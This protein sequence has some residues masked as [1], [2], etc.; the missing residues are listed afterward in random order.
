MSGAG[1]VFNRIGVDSVSSTELNIINPG[2]ASASLVVELVSSGSSPILMPL[3]LAA[4]GVAQ[5]DVATFFGVSEV[6]SDSYVK[7]TSDV[8]IA[9]F[10]FVRTVGQ[11]LLDLNAQPAEDQLSNLYFPQLAVLGPWETEL[12]LVNTSKQSVILTLSVFQENG[13]LFDTGDLENN[14]IV[15]TLDGGAS[16]SEDVEAM[17]GFTGDSVQQG[18]LLVESTSAAINGSISYGLAGSVASVAASATGQKRALFSHIATSGVF[19]PEW[20]S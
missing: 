13:F 9:G 10:E 7:V 11:D 8:E 12:N 15:R 16:L 17:F 1:I 2:A 19:L 20:H 4:M 14:P 3:S 5:L 18:W 6:S